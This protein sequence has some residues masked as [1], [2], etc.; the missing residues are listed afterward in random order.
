M[1]TAASSSSTAAGSY[2]LTVTGTSAAITQ[3]TT[4]EVTV[5][6]AAPA[7]YALT[8]SAN[9]FLSPGATTGNTTTI[10]V[11]PS[12]GFMG[13][14]ALACAFTSNASTNPA[15]CS[16]SPS[17]VDITASGAL[18]ST[19][20]INTTAATSAEKQVKPLFWPSTGG[21]AVAF[22]LFFLA[23]RRWRHRLA[24]L[25]VLVVFAGLAGMG[26][27]GGGGNGG[28]GNGGGGGGAGS[29][30]AGTTAGSYTV[31]VTGTSA[32]GSQTT[33]VTVTVN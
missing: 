2:A 14:V 29:G 27:G 4:V 21:A 5:N 32:S 20:T 8:T 22:L 10:T 25:G 28:S 23:P 33:T 13:T 1:L 19:L 30:S 26:C 17:S 24:M 6:P 15:T 9:I 11:T 18:T 3:T 12:N 16:L 31:T 7:I